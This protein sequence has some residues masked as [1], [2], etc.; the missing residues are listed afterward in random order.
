MYST[1][2]RCTHRYYHNRS[3][4]QTVW[5][6]PVDLTAANPSAGHTTS[7]EEAMTQDPPQTHNVFLE[8]SPSASLQAI[9]LPA[10][11]R[12]LKKTTT[13]A[14]DGKTWPNPGDLVKVLYTGYVCHPPSAS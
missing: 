10:T 8:T 3:T 11:W 9:D 6:C 1:F 13:I 5:D 7:H 14:G 12:P 4:G 2:F